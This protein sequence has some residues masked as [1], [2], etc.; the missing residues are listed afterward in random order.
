M[1]YIKQFDILLN[2]KG[3]KISGKEQSYRLVGNASSSF[4]LL[5]ENEAAIVKAEPSGA[6]NSFLLTA[7]EA[8]NSSQ[9]TFTQDPSKGY[10]LAI[11][12]SQIEWNWTYDAANSTFQLNSQASE[13]IA[14]VH[15]HNLKDQLFLKISINT[16]QDKFINEALVVSLCLICNLSQCDKELLSW[17]EG[18]SLF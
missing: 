9:A 7:L 2:S 12:S 6:P 15:T 1:T 10:T 3:F 17:L 14:S 4:E 11:P 13:L 8:G 18:D 5:D 16:Q